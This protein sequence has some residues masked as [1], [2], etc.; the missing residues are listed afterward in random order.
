M[1]NWT[2]N[3]WDVRAHDGRSREHVPAQPV[4]SAFGMRALQ[5]LLAFIIL[6]MTAYAAGQ[7]GTGDLAGFGLAWFTFIL[8]FGYI[9]YLAVSLFIAPHI[10]NYWAQLYVP[11]PKLALF[12]EQR[13]R[14]RG[15]EC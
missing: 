11:A 15:E 9:I 14:R 6:V 1:V 13:S 4:W 2:A 10:Y 5:L 3:I 7:F 12:Y 8:T